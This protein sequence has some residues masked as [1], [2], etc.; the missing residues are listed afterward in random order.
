VELWL[1][2]QHEWAIFVV[3]TLVFAGAAEAG[4]R[5]AGR[6]SDTIG[7]RELAEVSTIQAA[8]LGLVALLLGFTFSMAATRFDAR[9]E[10]VRDEA[11]AIGTAWLRAELLPEPQRGNVMRLL[12]SYVDTRFELQRTTG[13]PELLRAANASA[14][15]LQNR[16]WAE[17]KAAAER[18]QR[19]VTTGLFIQSLNDM[20]D[21]H[22]KQVAAMRNRIPFLIALV[23]VIATA[24]AMA[25]T[26]Y[27]ASVAGRHSP[28]LSLVMSLLMAG[29]LTMIV[30]LHRPSRGLI[31]VD[32]QSLVEAREAMTA[33]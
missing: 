29:V 10:L 31:T 27:A 13:E 23:L 7:D 30:D 18:D 4:S 32:L 17:A 21:M 26:G 11:N 28:A 1:A 6:R 24:V 5:L 33:K 2:H 8:V 16:L 20:I 15:A 25:I 14:G 19:S 22:G 9:K 3:L 12:R